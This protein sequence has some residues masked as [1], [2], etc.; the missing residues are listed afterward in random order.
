MQYWNEVITERSWNKL[1]ELKRMKLK[2]I[3]IG[4]WACYL[5]TKAQKSKDI[6]IIVDLEELYKFKGMFSLRKNPRLKRYEAVVDG[7]DIDIYVPHYSKLALPVKFII[8][9]STMFEGFDVCKPEA[10][11]ILK[12]QAEFARKNSEK[13]LKDRIDIMGLLIKTDFDFAKYL[14]IVKEFHL[15]HFRKRLIEIVSSFREYSYL[16]MSWQKLRKERQKILS[17]IKSASE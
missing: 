14:N 4:G 5:W 1:Q 10:L 16:N 6:D 15:E 12:Q 9:E 8:K 17:N 7:V 11:L 13:G 2:F 3:L